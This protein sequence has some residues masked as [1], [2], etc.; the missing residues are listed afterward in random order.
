MT[1]PDFQSIMLP[2]L[3]HLAD[4]Q[5]QSNVETLGVLSD[6]FQLSDEER[7]Q[8]LPCGVSTVFSNRVAWAKAHFK[9]AGLI[10]SPRR[11][12]YRITD[13]GR[14]ILREQPD[15]IDLKFL[16]R[17]PAH[18][19]FKNATRKAAGITQPAIEASP[20]DS[21]LTPEEHIELG[22]E[23]IREQLSDE[24]LQKVREAAPD[25]FERLVIDLLLAMGYQ[26]VEVIDGTG[27]RTSQM[28]RNAGNSAHDSDASRGI[29]NTSTGC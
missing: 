17:F 6:H 13:L 16:N 11:A 8:L 9:K 7:S 21:G 15:R 29:L 28:S 22:Y 19:E 24:L 12:V 1:I 18:R 4:G 14:D 20:S 2:L 25:F 27:R 10:D 23:Q 26:P 3:Q 5:E